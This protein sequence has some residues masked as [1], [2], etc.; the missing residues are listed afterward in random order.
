MNVSSKKL[1][2]NNPIDEKQDNIIDKARICKE[3]L[4]SKKDSSTMIFKELFTTFDKYTSLSESEI[5]NAYNGLRTKANNKNTSLLAVFG[6][7]FGVISLLLKDFNFSYF[8]VLNCS[9]I[10]FIIFFLLISAIHIIYSIII[11]YKYL[12]I[13]LPEDFEHVSPESILDISN[14]ESIDEIIIDYYINKNISYRLQATIKNQY[15]NN[16]LSKKIE[17]MSINLKKYCAWSLI[18]LT[19]CLI[20]FIIS[21]I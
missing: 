14:L 21:K 13:S 19:F 5:L 11:F 2:Q 9:L 1:K 3:I 15:E 10:L 7:N 8:K 6:F 12:D 18:Y 4:N 16:R 20:L 17:K